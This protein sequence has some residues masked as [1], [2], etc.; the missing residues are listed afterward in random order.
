MTILSDRQIR[1]LCVAPTH[2]LDEEAYYR[3]LAQTHSETLVHYPDPRDHARMLKMRDERIRRECTVETTEEE[4]AAFRPMIHPFYPH[5]VREVVHTNQKMMGGSL[6]EVPSRSRK[7]ISM[8]TSSYGYDISC[9]AEHF[10]LFTNHEAGFIDPK[11]FDTKCLVDAKIHTDEDGAQFFWLPPNNYALGR[12]VEYFNFPRD[13]TAVF[14][15]KSTYARCA[16]IVNVTPGEAG[17]HGHL[18]V[19]IGNLTGLPM[20]I[21]ANEGI[22]Q[23]LFFQGSEECETSYGD[24]NGKYQGQRD[25]QLAKV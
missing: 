25:L 1:A 17:W 3:R 18:V 13:V 15:G 16:C 22:A 6:V 19:E 9:T 5:Q 11:R 2:R 4:R 23:A 24:R 8:G 7:I 20:K 14:V 12:T 21:Y 10:K